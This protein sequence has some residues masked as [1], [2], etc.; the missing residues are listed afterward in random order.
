MCGVQCNSPEQLASDVT[1]LMNDRIMRIF[2]PQDTRTCFIKSPTNEITPDTSP[3]LPFPHDVTSGYSRELFDRGCLV[4][5]VY[6]TLKYDAVFCELRIPTTLWQTLSNISLLK[7]EKKNHKNYKQKFQIPTRNVNYNEQRIT[8]TNRKEER[9]MDKE[10]GARR[11]NLS[12]SS[13]YDKCQISLKSDSSRL[14]KTPLTHVLFC[15]NYW[16]K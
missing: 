6:L 2:V 5:S 3:S 12:S 16:I 8:M 7:K 14:L 15:E 10:T 1:L 13:K 9:Q 4:D 11:K